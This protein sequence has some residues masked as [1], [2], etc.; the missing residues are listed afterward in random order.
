VQVARAAGLPFMKRTDGCLWPILDMIVET[1]IDVLDPIE[2][3]AGM[4]IG[5]VKEAYGDRIALAG[6]VDCSHVLPH[7]TLEDVVEAVKETLAKG[8]VGGGLIL[9]SSNSIHPAVKPENYRVMVEAA[10]EHGRYP[11]DPDMVEQYRRKDYAAPYR[12]QRLA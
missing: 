8:G 6:N 10:R 1:G 4:D 12:Q 2:P 9:A 7:G 5:R 3:V 11:L